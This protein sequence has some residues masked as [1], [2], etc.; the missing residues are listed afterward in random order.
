MEATYENMTHDA[1]FNPAGHQY[2]TPG[3]SKPGTMVLTLLASMTS[4]VELYQESVSSNQFWPGN[5]E[6]LRWRKHDI[7]YLLAL[8]TLTL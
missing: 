1:V 4:F 3:S 2:G 5:A 6:L 7:L 8:C